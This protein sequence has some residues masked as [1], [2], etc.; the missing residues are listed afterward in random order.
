M[1]L[2]TSPI[3]AAGKSCQVKGMMWPT[4]WDRST[5]ADDDHSALCFIKRCAQRSAVM[6]GAITKLQS[7][8]KP[9]LARR[10]SRRYLAS[11]TARVHAVATSYQRKVTNLK[12][13]PPGELRN[14]IKAAGA[15]SAWE[16]SDEKAIAYPK[17]KRDGE[18]YR[19]IH[20]HG[21]FQYALERLSADA[22][23]PLVDILPTQFIGQ[24][25]I[26]RLNAWLRENLPTTALVMTVDIPR[27]F[28]T[29]RRSCLVDTLRLPAWVV[30]RV[31][32]DPMDK[33]TY[34]YHGPQGLVPQ[35][36]PIA[37]VSSDKRGIPQG[38]ALS[39]LASDAVI[40]MVMRSISDI[41]PGIR[42][43]SHGDNIIILMEAVTS[44]A[45]VAHA[46]TSA[47]TKCFGADVSSELTCRIR[48]KA[49]SAGFSFCR[50]NYAFKKGGLK[51]ALPADWVDDFS[52]RTLDKIERA[53]GPKG[54]KVWDS[55]ERS[56]KGWIRH[57]PKSDKIINA[58]MEL[59]VHVKFMRK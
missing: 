57:S 3:G 55:I 51:I 23:R 20:R 41:G 14:L 8:G 25:G 48:C 29:I 46:L 42:V 50:R 10:A 36:G 49:P 26:P 52:L 38:S 44:K 45:S 37:K 59:L 2:T 9:R 39:Q 27:C 40:A 19:W 35:S 6:L 18:S 28:D 24:G 11:F 30:Q 56:I 17:W 54:L 16:G 21:L 32:F 4:N 12:N 1:S 22:A 13:A 31:L 33:A 47:V 15:L 5:T 58:G 34:L 43:A 53:R 7:G